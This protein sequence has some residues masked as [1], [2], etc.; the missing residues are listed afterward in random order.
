MILNVDGSSFGNPVVSGYGG[1]IRNADDAWVYDFVGNI[2]YFNIL[3][4]ELMMLY[5]G[6]SITHL[7]SK[8]R[9]MHKSIPID[10]VFN[11]VQN[12]IKMEANNKDQ[13]VEVGFVVEVVSTEAGDAPLYALECL[14]MHF[15]QNVL[16]PLLDYALLLLWS[17]C[18]YRAYL[19]NFI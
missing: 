18:I 14:C 6:L 4:P 15:H 8:F 3:H 19:Y 13:I 16:I 2:G 10:R 12:Q 17:S 1:L 11:F 5:H 9:R 7:V